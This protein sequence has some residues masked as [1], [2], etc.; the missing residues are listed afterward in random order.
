[1]ELYKET[2]EQGNALG[3]FELAKAAMSP[4]GGAAPDL[5]MAYMYANLAAVRQFEEAATLRD[6]LEAQMTTEQVVSAQTKSQEWTA[7]RIAAAAAPASP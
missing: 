7:A 3:L 4:E 5:V 1:M 6:E 2:A